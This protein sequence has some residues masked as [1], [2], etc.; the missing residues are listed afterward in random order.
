MKPLFFIV[1]AT[2]FMLSCNQ[3]N[4]ESENTSSY[5]VSGLTILD[6]SFNDFTIAFDK[7]IG[8]V[9]LI[10]K[11]NQGVQYYPLGLFHNTENTNPTK[12]NVDT[13]SPNVYLFTVISHLKTGNTIGNNIN[14]VS[15]NVLSKKVTP[16]HAFNN[17]GAFADTLAYDTL[18]DVKF[19]DY[20]FVKVNQKDSFLFDI[21]EYKP[22]KPL[23]QN[24]SKKSKYLTAIQQ[25]PFNLKGL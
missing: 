20:K 4:V 9:G 13:L 22:F 10:V 7:N 23:D 25:H 16:I 8:Q 24:L 19:F 15:Y 6:S 18:K 1:T 3:K 12:I 14:L 11:E 5:D 21:Q 2:V 17:L